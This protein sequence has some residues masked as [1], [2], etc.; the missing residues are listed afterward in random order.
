MALITWCRCQCSGRDIKEESVFC[1][2]FL[3]AATVKDL[4]NDC[5]SDAASIKE[6][7]KDMYIQQ[8]L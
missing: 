7:V 6:L 5:N 3:P 1:L 8:V 4:V 2:G